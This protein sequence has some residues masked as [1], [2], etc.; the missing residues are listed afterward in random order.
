L[1]T[2]PGTGSASEVDEMAVDLSDSFRMASTSGSGASR[3]GTQRVVSWYDLQPFEVEDGASRLQVSLSFGANSASPMV[4]LRRPDGLR[5]KPAVFNGSSTVFVVE[6][7]DPGQWE[8]VECTHGYDSSICLDILQPPTLPPDFVVAGAEGDALQFSPAG[9]F[10]EVPQVFAE[11][12]VHG[13]MS[14]FALADVEMTSVD[15]FGA[16]AER[17]VGKD[18]LLRAIPADGASILGAQVAATIRTPSGGVVTIQLKDEGKTADGKA[19]DGVYGA[20]FRDGDDAGAYS[21]RIVASGTGT[22]VGPFQREARTAF[23]LHDGPDG[24]VDEIPDFLDPDPDRPNADEDADSDGLTNLEE[25]VL[26]TNP[27]NPDTDGGGE[28]D[29]SEVHRVIPTNP[30]DASD[31]DP[32]L[33]FDFL[34]SACPGGAGQL[35]RCQGQDHRG[36]ISRRRVRAVH[37]DPRATDG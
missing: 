26:H 34:A 32:D 33:E 22:L 27:L 30:L 36:S 29:G 20:R 4:R 5:H 9:Y 24:D 2:T 21:V 6:D 14:L 7:P 8:Y 19:G 18:V 25:F 1:L 17:F 16:E 3:I 23:E 11:Q 12:I 35:R 37:D 28:P 10:P 31:D 15:K 13:A